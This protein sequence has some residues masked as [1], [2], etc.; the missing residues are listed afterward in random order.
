MTSALIEQLEAEIANL[1]A[2]IAQGVNLGLWWTFTIAQFE[3]WCASNLMTDAEID[4]LATLPVKLRTNLKS[5]NAFV[6]N[7]GR[8]LIIFRDIVKWLVRNTL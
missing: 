6:R 5:N 2:E 1:R 3:D 8:T 7:A 4:A